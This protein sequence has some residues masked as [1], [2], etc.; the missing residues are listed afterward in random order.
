MRLFYEGADA[1]RDSPH[2]TPPSALRDYEEDQGMSAGVRW[3]NLDSFDGTEIRVRANAILII[4]QC[5]CDQ[6]HAGFVPCSNRGQG[7]FITLMGGSD[8]HCSQTGS[9]VEARIEAALA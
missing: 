8:V 7:S 2:G 5:R 6:S 3:V 1:A 9:E 4:C